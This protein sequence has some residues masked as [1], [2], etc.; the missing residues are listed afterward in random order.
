VYDEG[1][2]ALVFPAPLIIR[3]SVCLKD[4]GKSAISG[5][6]YNGTGVF[7]FTTNDGL[8]ML[9]ASEAK[10]APYDRH[11]CFNGFPAYTLIKKD[12]KRGKAFRSALF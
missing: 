6:S 1:R 12:L 9:N 2:K 7:R 8:R 4:T 5:V 3:V 11:L 10:L